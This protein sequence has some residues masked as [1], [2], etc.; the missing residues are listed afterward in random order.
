MAPNKPILTLSQSVPANLPIPKATE[1]DCDRSSPVWGLELFQALPHHNTVQYDM[2]F[3]IPQC[4]RLSVSI[5][6][7]KDD[8]DF[9]VLLFT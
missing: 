2:L 4:F 6:I 3:H 1:I 8:R 9:C 5:F 7:I